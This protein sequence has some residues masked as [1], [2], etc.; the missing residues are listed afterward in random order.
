[1]FAELR[2]IK[3]EKYITIATATTV[4][5]A[6]RSK[7]QFLPLPRLLF[8]YILTAHRLPRPRRSSNKFCQKASSISS[9]MAREVTETNKKKMFLEKVVIRLLD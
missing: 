6:D 4:T 3:K 8:V 7:E 5:E 2:A 1:L 9:E